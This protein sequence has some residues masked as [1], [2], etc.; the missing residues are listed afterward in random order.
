MPYLPAGCTRPDADELEA[1]WIKAKHAATGV[2]AWPE[3]FDVRWIGLDHESTEQ[4]ID[5]I[6][7]N[8]KTGTFTLPW[9]TDHTDQ[10]TPAVGDAI[11]LIDFGGHPRL[12]VRLRT[13][14]TVAF[15]NITA[16]H[17]AIDGSPVRDIAIWKP[18]HTH[19][20]NAMLAPFGLAVTTDMPVWI[21]TFE[22]LA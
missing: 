9:I 6:I 2:P 1:F 5:L 12:I 4:V 3:H 8:D 15:G 18:L 20:W 13:I 10:P 22:R 16:Q 19:Y 7:D 21:E 17:T 14:Q 11:I